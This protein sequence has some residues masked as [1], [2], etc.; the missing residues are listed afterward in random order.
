MEVHLHSAAVWF[1]DTNK[2]VTLEQHGFGRRASPHSQMLLGHRWGVGPA[3][4]EA[5]SVLVGFGAMGAPEG[6]LRCNQ[7]CVCKYENASTVLNIILVRRHH[8]NNE[9]VPV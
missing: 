7:T 2:P 4:A 1:S 3:C 9:Q 6:W 8:V 5:A